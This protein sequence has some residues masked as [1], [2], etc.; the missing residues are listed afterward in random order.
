MSRVQIFIK[1]TF[2]KPSFCVI[3]NY[4]DGWVIAFSLRLKEESPDST[5]K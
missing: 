1:K 3:T 5:G 4:L 2:S